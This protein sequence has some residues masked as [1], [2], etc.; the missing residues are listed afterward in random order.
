[1]N[2]AYGIILTSLTVI[3]ISMQA[4][5]EY[6][7]DPITA[8][9]KWSNI[10]LVKTEWRRLDSS[11]ESSE[12]KKA[13]LNTLIDIA[14]QIADKAEIPS[15]APSCKRNYWAAVGGILLSSFGSGIFF[16]G[17]GYHGRNEHAE[18]AYYL[19]GGV[20]WQKGLRLIEIGAG[21]DENIQ[22]PTANCGRSK[23]TVILA[24]LED[25]LRDVSNKK[26]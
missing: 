24:Y 9:I 10:A 21:C 18:L 8:A 22:A 23:A 3:S 25:L 1:M 15:V 16:V 2:K 17:L 13:V 7:L 4:K 11:I 14:A 6:E 5:Q 12:D 19:V 26:S 20:P